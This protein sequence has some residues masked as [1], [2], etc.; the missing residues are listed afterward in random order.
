MMVTSWLFLGLLSCLCQALKPPVSVGLSTD[1]SDEIP[2][3][4]DLD[5]AEKRGNVDRS[6]IRFGRSDVEDKRSSGRN[7]LRFGRGGDY[8]DDE[9]ESLSATKRNRNFLRFGRSRNFLRFGRNR[10][11]LRF[12][13]SR[14]FLRFGR[15]DPED[16]G[17]ESSNPVEV[18]LPVLE[19]PAAE[20]D[21][22]HR[23]ARG[24]RNFLRFGRQ[25]NKNFLRFGRSVD[26]PMISC[27]DC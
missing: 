21:I 7:F 8:E 24:N 4:G 14:N 5:L 20:V 25:Y 15:S 9:N 18:P 10:N 19:E 16:I 1:S 26:S 3:D 2:H 27:D 12:G 13:R 17:L 23:A 22:F 11:F 6:F